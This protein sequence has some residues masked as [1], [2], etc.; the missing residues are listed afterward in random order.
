MRWYEKPEVLDYIVNSYAGVD[1]GK[2]QFIW[3]DLETKDL[4]IGNSRAFTDHLS[5]KFNL[6]LTSTGWSA[7][8]E[9]L[10]MLGEVTHEY[11]PRVNKRGAKFKNQQPET[12]IL[13]RRE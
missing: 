11:A 3:E 6:D 5:N 13:K 10:R 9:A 12:H 2:R 7:V 4:L 8:H 1:H